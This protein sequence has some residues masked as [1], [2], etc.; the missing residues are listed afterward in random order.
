MEEPW[1]LL[2]VRCAIQSTGDGHNNS[3][4]AIM[5]Q[6]QD[7]KVTKYVSPGNLRKNSSQ[8][9]SPLILSK[10]IEWHALPAIASLGSGR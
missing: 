3:R 2:N 7:Y 4:L 10:S 6:K 9:F 5:N 1:Y 8:Q